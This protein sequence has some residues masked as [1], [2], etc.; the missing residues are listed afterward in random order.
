M[1]RQQIPI[2]RLGV[3]DRDIRRFRGI[4]LALLALLALLGIR[5]RHGPIQSLLQHG[6][7]LGRHLTFEQQ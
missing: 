2:R 7:D 4:V 6:A 5:P 3:P 1:H